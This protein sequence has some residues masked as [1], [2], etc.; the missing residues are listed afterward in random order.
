VRKRKEN[1]G[2]GPKVDT[3]ES[4]RGGGGWNAKQRQKDKTSNCGRYRDA[5]YP[6]SRAVE[7]R[8]NALSRRCHLGKVQNKTGRQW[9]SVRGRG[10]VC[11]MAS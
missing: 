3:L 2:I 7:K 1:T 11:F 8:P 9:V 10:L 4:K 6:E 5:R